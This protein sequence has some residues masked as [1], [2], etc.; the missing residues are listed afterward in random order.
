MRNAPPH[1]C[2]GQRLRRNRDPQIVGD[3]LR[4]LVD[5]APRAVRVGGDKPAAD[6]EGRE[7]QNRAAVDQ[8][9]L[10]RAAADVGVEEA[11]IARFRQRHSARAVRGEPA[12]ELVAGGG[13]DEF[14][15]IGGEQLVDGAGVLALDRLAGE[16]HRAGI[17][18]ALRKARVGITAG[19]EVA[20][21]GRVDGA[22]GQE[23]GEQDRRA[24]D[25][26]AADDD[27]AAG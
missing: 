18:F 5:A 14:P 6:G 4:R 10:G 20:E 1:R 3:K 22:V 8:G 13:A 9:E 2:I 26:F 11:S 7:P 25:D 16:D 12:F 19:D 15:G 24:P 21:F 17:D 23:R 27:E